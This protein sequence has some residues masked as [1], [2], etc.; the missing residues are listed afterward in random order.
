[1]NTK[2]HIFCFEEREIFSALDNQIDWDNHD[3][4]ITKWTPHRGAIKVISFRTTKKFSKKVPNTYLKTNGDPLPTLYMDFTKSCLSYFKRV[5]GSKFASVNAFLIELK[6]LYFIMYQRGEKDPTLLTR[7]HFEECINYLKIIEYK[8]IYNSATNLKVISDLIDEKRLTEKPINYTINIKNN[9]RYYSKKDISSDIDLREKSKLPSFEAMSSYAICTN[10]PI[11][12][13][14]EILLRTIDLL[15]VT[16]MRAN[17]VCYIPYDCWVEKLKLDKKGSPILDMNG[18]ELKS[19][20]IRYYAEKKFKDRVHWL[21]PQDVPF[22]K[23]AI[24]RLKILTKEARETSLWQENNPGRLWKY[25]KNKS[26][27]DFELLNTSLGFNKIIYLQGYLRRKGIKSLGTNKNYFEYRSKNSKEVFYSKYYNVGDIEKELLN[28]KLMQRD[29]LIDDNGKVILKLS[30]VLALRFDGAF[31]FKRS[32]NILWVYPGLVSVKEINEALGANDSIESIFERRN[33]TEAD[34]SKIRLTSHKPRHWRNTLYEL[35][36]MSNVQQALALGRQN[37][38]QNKAYQHT[39]IREKTKLHQQYLSF[40]SVTEKIRFLQEGIRNKNILGEMTETYHLLKN[41][42][43]IEDAETFLKTHGLALHLTPFG[44]C[45][46]DF[47]QS[48]CLKHLQCWN[49]CS[50]LHRT[51]TPG[52]TERLLEQL[53]FAKK[54]LN[55]IRGDKHNNKSKWEKDILNKIKNIKKAIDLSPT[56]N[57]IQMFPDGI[58]MTKPNYITRKESL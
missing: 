17:E 7:W 6:R 22:A 48:P 42:K 3:W 39:T 26:V 28:T 35:A 55:K 20:G 9:H 13:N 52:E 12:E 57:P 41:N 40:N 15:I 44:G 11:N 18:N 25:D 2:L 21:A 37:L 16:G 4:N 32:S 36:G 5:R 56:T 23:R 49:G 51:N 24:D 54:N 14:E 45:T 8:N 29:V 10:N 46:H 50:H 34:G 47:S 30:E 19:F 53:E 33:L 1:M 58:E 27:S 38:T 43:S 31:R